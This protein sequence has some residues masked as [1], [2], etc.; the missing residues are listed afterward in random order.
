MP[1]VGIVILISV[2]DAGSAAGVCQNKV[3]AGAHGRSE[4]LQ[5]GGG[6]GAVE[7]G[8]CLGGGAEEQ[9]GGEAAQISTGNDEEGDD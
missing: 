2:A 7:W 1:T 8:G 5:G 9:R 3:G 6:T 4:A